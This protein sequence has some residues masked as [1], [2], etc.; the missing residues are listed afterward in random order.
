MRLKPVVAFGLFLTLLSTG[1]TMGASRENRRP[2]SRTWA[3]QSKYFMVPI[4]TQYRVRRDIILNDQFYFFDP[5]YQD[6]GRACI[7]TLA[8]SLA[9]SPSGHVIGRGNT[10]TVVNSNTT[11]DGRTNHSDSLHGLVLE[12]SSGTQLQLR[13]I[14]EGVRMNIG[15]VAPNVTTMEYL[16]RSYLRRRGAFPAQAQQGPVRIQESQPRG[17]QRI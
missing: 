2:A 6:P 13:C 10:L 7:L 4:G 1:T 9:P 8:K 15:F 3:D 14:F 5:G 16:F 12:T 11:Y 17:P